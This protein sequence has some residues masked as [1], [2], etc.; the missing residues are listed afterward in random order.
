MNKLSTIRSYGKDISMLFS[1]P[2][3]GVGVTQQ[4]FKEECDIN[5]IVKRFGI[6]GELPQ[7]QRHPLPDDTTYGHTEYRE[8]LDHVIKV[9]RAF[10][11]MDVNV[12]NRFAND[13]AKL[14][15]FVDDP[16]N[17]EEAVRLGIAVA[18]PAP[19]P[20]APPA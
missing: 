1:A 8:L 4:Q 6:T 17:Q 3:S 5:T 19:P 12:R 7:H 2:A 18:K 15:D 14:L 9:Q 20:P 13:P 16:K 10:N 11:D